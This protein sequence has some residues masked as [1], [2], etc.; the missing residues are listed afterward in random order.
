M[1]RLAQQS[2]ILAS[3]EAE[4]VEAEKRITAAWIAVQRVTVLSDADLHANWRA[5]TEIREALEQIDARLTA[6]AADRLGAIV[7]Q[8]GGR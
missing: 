1:T 8:I 6:Q 5:I 3:I 4:R 2:R 7:A